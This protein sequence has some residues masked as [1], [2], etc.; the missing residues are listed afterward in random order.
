MIL[1]ILLFAALIAGLGYVGYRNVGIWQGEVHTSS[2]RKLPGV[3]LT[4][5]ADDDLVATAVTD[6]NGEFEL[7]AGLHTPNQRLV[8]CRAGYL[9]Q[10]LSD[11]PRGAPKKPGMGSF[12]HYTLTAGRIDD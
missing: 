12:G 8:I 4:L 11:R 6:E 1:K 5:L 7:N 10:L 2:K 9:P 3:T